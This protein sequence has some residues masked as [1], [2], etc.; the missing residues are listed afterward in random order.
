MKHF[1]LILGSL[2]LGALHAQPLPLDERGKVSFYEV[3][4]ADSMKAGVLYANAK[5]WL[6]G[7]G[8]A[9][10]EADSAAGRLVASR[11]LAAYDKGYVTKKLHGKVHYRLMLEAKDQKY[12]YQ[13][14]DFVF[15]YYK[16][17]RYYRMVPAG[18]TKDLAETT[19]SGW[20]KLW[21]KHRRNAQLAV[22]E[23]I[24][25]LK[26]AAL[27]R[28]RVVGELAHKSKETW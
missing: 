16:E 15:A 18:K 27:V 4:K 7:E 26:T 1:I 8:Y 13:F 6:L 17:D 12:R 23:D 20:Q 24:R 22:E 3:V 9:V 2:A 19:A 14:T 25:Q 11:A 21:Q 28:P 10:V 5:G